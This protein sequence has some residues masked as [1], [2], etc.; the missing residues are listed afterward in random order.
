[1]TIT[2]EHLAK[3]FQ[4]GPSSGRGGYRT[5][6]DTLSNL[7]SRTNRE[8]NKSFWALQD[9]NFRIEAGEKVGIIGRN[10]AGKSTLLKLLSRIY[11]PT[12]GRIRIQGRLASLL[13]VG[14]G[15][16]PELSGR[17]N[18]YF[19]GAMLGM[20]KAEIRRKLDQIV[21]FSEIGPFLD[22]PVKQY[23]SGM[24]MRLGFSVAAHLESDILIL[25]E[26]LAVGDASFQ[27][28]CL[29]RIQDIA[30]EG[31]TVIFVSHN[32]SS[33][34]QF[35]E[36]VLL[37]ESGRIVHDGDSETGVAEYLGKNDMASRRDNLVSKVSW[38]QV[39][40][41]G[42]EQKN[43]EAG[44]NRPLRFSLNLDSARELPDLTLVL[45][46]TNTLGARLITG[47]TCL[48]VFPVGEHTLDM[49][50]PDHRL[51][52]GT[53]F[54]SLAIRAEG[55]ALFAEEQILCFELVADQIEDSHLL[56]LAHKARDRQ[57]CYC[58]LQASLAPHFSNSSSITA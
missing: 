44:F 40:G 34:L 11:Q 25:D 48:E 55:R 4:I 17:E 6:R 47:R 15:F 36:R 23:S 56:A 26:V 53:Y 33:I 43:M 24:Y 39:L 29:A 32:M 16:H 13:E 10:G 19:N 30:R 12:E 8:E 54:I 37:L 28:K 18:I 7:F 27:N 42:L 20:G 45:G 9:I 41:F 57:G 14:T 58:V 51:I 5:V 50:M 49:Q 21:A 22:T 35:T 3:R 38:F 31:R 46:I 2:V 52:P 1:M